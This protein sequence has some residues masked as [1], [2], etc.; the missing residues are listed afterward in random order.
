MLDMRNRLALIVGGGTVGQ[1]K[2]HALLEA[3][4]TV[5]IIS[6][7]N[8]QGLEALRPLGVEVLIQDYRP[9]LLAGARLVIACTDDRELNARIA[10]DAR[11]IGALVN[12]ADQPEDCDFFLPAVAARGE[13]IVAVGTGGSSPSLAAGLRD[14]LAAALPDRIEHFA[15]A[16]ESIRQELRAGESTMER[17]GEIMKELSGQGGYLLF[18][19]EGVSGLRRRLGQLL[20]QK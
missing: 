11:R 7:D 8:S 16:L 1:R 4:A 14:I 20:E 13:I 17:R 18:M 5:R 19:A 3:G 9:E 10:S 15:Q 2:T 6:K 12:A